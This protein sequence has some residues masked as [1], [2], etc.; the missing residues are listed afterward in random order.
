VVLVVQAVVVQAHQTSP[1]LLELLTQAVVVVAIMEPQA[2]YKL[3]Q[4]AALAL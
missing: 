2:Q 1:Q 3:A 4:T